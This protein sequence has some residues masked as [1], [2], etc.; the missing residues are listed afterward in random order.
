[1]PGE[2]AAMFGIDAGFVKDPDAV[3]L[4]RGFAEPGDEYSVV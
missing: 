3:S 1:M 4:L 2:T